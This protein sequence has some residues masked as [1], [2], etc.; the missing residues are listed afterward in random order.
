M[1]R[2]LFPKV[3]SEKYLEW[4]KSSDDPQPGNELN[5]DKF[6]LIYGV[7]GFGFDNDNDYIVTKNDELQIYDKISAD[8]KGLHEFFYRHNQ[9]PNKKKVKELI[10]KEV[11]KI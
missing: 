5:F 8:D 1:L 6:S 7:N 2:R 4:I 9:L 10:K 11:N 3:V